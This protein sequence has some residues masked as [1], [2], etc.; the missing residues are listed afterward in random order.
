VQ[1]ILEIYAEPRQRYNYYMNQTTE[2]E[3]LLQKGEARAMAYAQL[4][5]QQLRQALGYNG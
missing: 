3:T 1:A 2:L 5:L 4:K